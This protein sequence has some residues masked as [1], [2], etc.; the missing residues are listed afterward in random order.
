VQFLERH[1]LFD[2]LIGT[3]NQ[4]IWDSDPQGSLEVD[5]EDRRAAR[6]AVRATW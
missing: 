4:H 2:H 5:R 6:C 1:T 3:A